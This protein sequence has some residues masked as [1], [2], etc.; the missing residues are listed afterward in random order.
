[1]TL[2]IKNESAQPPRRK[3]VD[4]ST[5][6]GGGMYQTSPTGDGSSP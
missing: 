3:L 4:V 5:S 6:G 2:N 1:M